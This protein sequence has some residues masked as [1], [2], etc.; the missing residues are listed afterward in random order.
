M[1]IV[2]LDQF[3]LPLPRPMLD[4]PL[5]AHGIYEELIF[6]V[7]HESRQAVSAGEPVENAHPVLVCTARQV[8]GGTFVKDTARPVC[9]DVAEAAGHLTSGTREDAPVKP[10]QGENFCKI[11]WS[12]EITLRG[13]DPRILCGAGK[14]MPRSSRGKVK[15]GELRWL[16]DQAFAPYAVSFSILFQSARSFARGTAMMARRNA[17]RCCRA[18]SHSA[19]CGA[20]GLAQSM[21]I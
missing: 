3:N 16:L 4:R 14:R 7:M 8:R 12:T 6:L 1:R 20:C 21:P 18:S 9:H 10:G 13:L 2:R 11:L 5:S 19:R 15:W 17:S